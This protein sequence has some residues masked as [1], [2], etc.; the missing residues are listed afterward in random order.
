MKYA[1]IIEINA[2]DLYP[3][4]SASRQ[5]K[6]TKKNEKKIKKRHIANAVFL[7]MSP[8][9]KGFLRSSGTNLSSSTSA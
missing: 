5:R 9:T 8:L 2:A 4:R 6:K 7:E 3:S 1:E